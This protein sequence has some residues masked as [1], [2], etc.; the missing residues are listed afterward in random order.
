MAAVL[1]M[2]ATVV[3]ALAVLQYRWHRETSDATGVRLADALQLSMINWH[4]DLFR[5][6]S[7]A[8]MAFRLASLDPDDALDRL[9][10]RLAEWRST[11]RYPDLIANVYVVGR[12]ATTGRLHVRTLDQT[13]GRF[14]SAEW[15]TRLRSLDAELAW[16]AP[17]TSATP[18]GRSATGP[19]DPSPPPQRWRFDPAPPALVHRLPPDVDANRAGGP[20]P[21]WLVIQFDEDVLR[22]RLMADLAHR[23]FQG[24]DGLDYQVAVVSGAAPYRVIYSSDAGFGEQDVFDA[25]GRM[26]VF[27]QLR[28]ETS[29][30]PVSVFHRTSENTGSASAVGVSWFPIV[31]D[32]PPDRQWHLIV[33]HRRGGPLGVFVIDMRRQGLALSLGA[34]SLL[35][36]SM[37]ML[38]ITSARAQRLA[39]L[40]MDF[41]AAVSHELRTPLTIIGSAADNIASGVIENDRQLYEYGSVIGGEVDHLSGLVEDVLSFAAIRNGQ[42]QY[43]M[44]ELQASEI[45]EVALARSARLIRTAQFTVERDVPAD[46]PTV[47][48]DPMAVS[49]CLVNLITN[50]LKYGKERRW[51][52]IRARVVD[53]GMGDQ[54][55]QI[56]VAD[57]GIGIDPQDIP[58][59]FDPFYRSPSVRLAQIQGTGLG[60]ALAKQ[61]AE[62]MGGSLTVVTTPGQ[63]STFTLS[64]R[65]M[66][67]SAAR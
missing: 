23:Y 49:Q 44:R 31:R 8:G 13:T 2:T 14:L 51:M 18:S 35:V 37:S 57:R 27:G 63:G 22:S 30:S 60:L 43:V 56:S 53:G 52:A 48:G 21:R 32:A 11:A 5:N 20:A 6:L 29:R 12:E 62:S 47:L 38:V 7:E 46:L 36:V 45:V 64:L 34:L 9:P 16:Q 41:V 3:V 33:R 58:R 59:I 40:Q 55:V 66:T 39:R 1:V 61:V 24:T 54:Q 67:P 15:P 26:D 42:Q 4:L 17:P 25:D 65:S 10:E 19:G 50:A 28:S